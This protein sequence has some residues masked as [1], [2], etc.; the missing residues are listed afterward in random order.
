ML[1]IRTDRFFIILKDI[2][3]KIFTILLAPNFF[4]IGKNTT[5]IPPFRFANLGLIKLG[6]NVCIHSNC[7]IHALKTQKNDSSPILTIENNVSIGQ[8]STISAA[9]KIIIEEYAFTAPNVYISD[10]GHEF[11]D[12]T[13]P[14]AKQGIRNLHEVRIGAHSWLGQNSAIL[15]GASI[16]KHCVIG[17]NSVVNS[18]IPDYSV[19]VGAPAKVIKTFNFDKNRWER[20]GK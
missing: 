1:K 16:G 6:N 15:P 19:A 20:V 18:N 3:N 2:R 10:H 4:D 9:K 12:I 13:L 8:N 14:I 5:I 17:A 7:W 11:H